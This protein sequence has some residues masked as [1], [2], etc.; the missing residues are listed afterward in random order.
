MVGKVQ[1]LHG[2][3]SGLYG[4]CSNGVT[5]KWVEHCKKCV[6]FRGMYSEKETITAPPQSSN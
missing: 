1:K 3:R 2:V 5:L 6:T 4:G